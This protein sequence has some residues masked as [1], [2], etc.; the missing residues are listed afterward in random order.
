MADLDGQHFISLAPYF[1]RTGDRN[2]A[3]AAL[4]FIPSPIGSMVGSL[5]AGIAIQESGQIRISTFTVQVMT[6]NNTGRT[7]KFKALCVISLALG[8]LVYLAITIR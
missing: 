2:T 3:T 6:D 8:A 5:I 7:N 1:L 4:D